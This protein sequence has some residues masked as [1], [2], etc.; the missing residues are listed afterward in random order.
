MRC[1]LLLRRRSGPPLL[2]LALLLALCVYLMVGDEPVRSD[3]CYKVSSLQM[4][5]RRFVCTLEAL[6]R[7]AQL[8]LLSQRPPHRRRAVVLT[9]RHPASDTEV[10]L[11]QRVLQQMDYEV[12]LSRYAETSSFLR[13][14]QGIGGWSL[15]LCLSTSEQ[16]CLRRI[17]FSHLQRHQTVNLLPGLIEAFSNVGGGLCRFY[18]H[19]QLTES[20]LPMNPHACGSTNQKL[21]IPLDSFPDSQAPP[22]ALVAMVNV[23]VLV[24]S[25][26]PLTSFL[27]DISVV[28]TIQHPRGQPVKVDTQLNVS[29]LS[30]DAFDQQITKDLILEDTL[31]FLLPPLSHLSSHTHLSSEREGSQY[32]GCTGTL[33]ICLSED[34]FLLLLHFQLLMKTSSAFQPLYPSV[35]SS[36]SLPC[37]LSDLPDLLTQI[38]RFYKLKTNRSCRTDEPPSQQPALSSS[39]DEGVCVDPHLR[40]IYTDPPLILT[41]PFHPLVKEYRAEVTFDTMTVRIRPEPVSSACRIHLDEHRGPRM[42]N[43]P[44]GLGNSKISI[45]VMDS[46]HPE[47]VI[48]SIYTVHVYRESRPSL[49][50]F[51]YHVM[52]SFVQDCSLLVQPGRPCGLQPHSGS[53]S[54]RNAC[55]SGH[56]SGRWVVPCLSCSDN[57]TCDWREV[58]WQP[59]GCYHPIVD[60]PLLQDCMKDRKLLF[61]GD[62]TNRGMMYFLME[63]VNSTLEDW[64]KAHDTLVYRNLNRGR[65]LV[66]YSY[67]P[68]FWL[69]KKQRPT[70][71][72][73]LQ[74][75]L[76]R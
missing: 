52:C 58:S 72:Q 34:E 75:L 26:T 35:S 67:Y 45:L 1:V 60:H 54:Q 57:R 50:M 53:Q 13:S 39:Q 2:L 55:S 7:H 4:L 17:S 44:V 21:Q 64:G 48:M 5:T 3:V 9:G 18:T 56:V 30:N 12:H 70:F 20:S 69:E 14:T 32:G 74:Q 37:S 41:P 38:E 49:P 19:S 68:Q 10:Q 23:Y 46:S 24:T 40:Q 33:G 31:H 73:A 6:Q 42:A 65:T 76:N 71:R 43:Y 61:I 51:G 59:D 25:V 47:P 62:S 66:S 29:G 8:Q 27:H 15:L 36:S 63:R 16:S 28:M 11:Y 22:P